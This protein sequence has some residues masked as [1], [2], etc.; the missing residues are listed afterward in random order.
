MTDH[1]TRRSI[2]TVGT[3]AG[4]AGLSMQASAASFG[5]PDEPPQG[6]INTT[7]HPRSLADPGPHSDAL[8]DQFPTSFSPPPT[9]IG[10]LP[11]F[12]ASF[13]NTQRRIHDRGWA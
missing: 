5:N 10:S 11:A 8:T 9:D 1:L 3:A 4:L 6:A 7:K 12:W 13:N 2:L